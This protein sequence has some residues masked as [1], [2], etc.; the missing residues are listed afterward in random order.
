MMRTD[1][2]GKT[3]EELGIGGG[4][5]AVRLV[6]EGCVGKHTKQLEIMKTCQQN[7]TKQMEMLRKHILNK[8]K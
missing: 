4:G 7:N 5:F 8:A 2:I 3:R 1:M 6:G